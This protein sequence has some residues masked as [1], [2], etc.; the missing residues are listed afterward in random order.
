MIELFQGGSGASYVMSAANTDEQF[1]DFGENDFSDTPARQYHMIPL[2]GS[3]YNVFKVDSTK[4][5]TATSGEVYVFIH[6][7][8]DSIE[9]PAATYEYTNVSLDFLQ[10]T[11][12]L[13]GPQGTDDESS[14]DDYNA[15]IRTETA[16]NNSPHS[17][18]RSGYQWAGRIIFG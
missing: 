12:G 18:Q 14:V 15:S 6:Q 7:S 1:Y 2:F 16:G 10:G 11:S 8:G 13:L 9:M 5:L 17:Q 4:I 3:F